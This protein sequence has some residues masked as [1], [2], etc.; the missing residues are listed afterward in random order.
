MNG[1]LELVPTTGRGSCFRVTLE[2]VGQGEATPRRR[3]IKLA[4]QS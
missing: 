1:R 2:I 3:R 4:S